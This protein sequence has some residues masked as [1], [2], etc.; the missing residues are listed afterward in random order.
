MFQKFQFQFPTPQFFILRSFCAKMSIPIFQFLWFLMFQVGRSYIQALVGPPWH[1]HQIPLF[2][3]RYHYILDFGPKQV[4]V[5]RNY[6]GRSTPSGFYL[7]RRGIRTD[8][9]STVVDCNAIPLGIG[10][11]DTIDENGEFAED[12]GATSVSKTIFH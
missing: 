2:W 12:G 8:T 11:E 3:P 4:N 7:A 6:D 10:D 5:G 9:S 1:V